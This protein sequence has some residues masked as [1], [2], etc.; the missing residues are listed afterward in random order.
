[1]L[2]LKNMYLIDIAKCV[3]EEKDENPI[4][5]IEDECNF[6]LDDIYRI[7]EVSDFKKE[8][9]P[10]ITMEF[11]KNCENKNIEKIRKDF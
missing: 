9:I 3:N 11:L 2:N 4:S 8:N 5:I 1:Y 10:E 6:I 7:I